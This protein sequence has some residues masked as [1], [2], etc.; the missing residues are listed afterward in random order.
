MFELPRYIG[1]NCATVEEA[2]EYVK[3]LDV[4]SRDH[5]WN[6]CFIISD[7]EG[8]SSLLEFSENKVFW[9]DEDKLDSYDW[10]RLRYNVNAIAQANFYL[11]ENAWYTQDIKSGEGRFITV[12]NG[13]N[14]VHSK[15]D[16]YELMKKVQY[17]NFYLDYD[18]CKDNCFDPRSENLGE[19]S[20]GVYEIIMDPSFEDTARK[21]INDMNDE[22]RRLTREQKM[23]ENKYWESIFTE[24]VDVNAQEIYVRMY[25]NEDQIYLIN[26][27][28]TKKIKTI[29]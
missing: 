9:F 26:M 27:D 11:N 17:S 14:D 21:M 2:K 20:W 10:L 16:M 22:V 19:V 8:A 29:E 7:S 28:E 12:Q 25:E 15:K 1:E 5:Y 13:I 24:V 23:D 18:E 6:Y 4:Y 3:T